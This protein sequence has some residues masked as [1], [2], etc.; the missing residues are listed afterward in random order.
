MTYPISLRS[1]ALDVLV[2]L[3]VQI[4]HV[5]GLQHS[6]LAGDVMGPWYNEELK[7]VSENDVARC[8]ALYPPP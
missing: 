1:Y 7:T 8:K 2:L 5:L 6:L 4:G 3:R